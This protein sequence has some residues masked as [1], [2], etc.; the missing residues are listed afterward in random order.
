MKKYHSRFRKT[1]KYGAIKTTVDNI[2]FDSKGEC[3]GWFDLK[4][5]EKEE[6][7]SDLRRQVLYKLEV[8]GVLVCK[9]IAD[10]EYIENGLIVTA[11]YKGVLTAEFRLKA[12][13]FKAIYGRDILIMKS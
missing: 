4:I 8:N 10:Y 1:N 12:K 6:E 3:K 2:T 7:I 9:Y 11:D 13:L 5:R